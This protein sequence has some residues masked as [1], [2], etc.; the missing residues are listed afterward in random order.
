MRRIL[1]SAVVA[2]VMLQACTKHSGGSIT[3]G[4]K[5][6]SE[7]IRATAEHSGSLLDTGTVYI[8]YAT[9][10]A[11]EDGV[12][13]DS[14]VMVVVND[15]PVATFS[16]LTTGNYYLLAKALHGSFS[17]PTVKGGK[18]FTASR[19]ENDWVPIPTYQYNP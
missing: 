6:G 9:L 11:P 7:T 13:D 18:S 17:P 15:T 3:G 12:Y 8:K 5:G 2:L 14:A 19:Q 16:G 4:G 1:L 10:D